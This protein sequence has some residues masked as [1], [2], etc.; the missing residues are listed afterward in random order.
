MN[1]GQHLR[2]NAIII[3]IY[4]HSALEFANLAAASEFQLESLTKNNISTAI[5]KDRLTDVVRR[6]PGLSSLQVT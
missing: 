5:D 6:D 4:L 2:P 1:C 3:Q